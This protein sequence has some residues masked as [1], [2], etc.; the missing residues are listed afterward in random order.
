M[1]DQGNEYNLKRTDLLVKIIGVFITLLTIVIGLVQ[2]LD[3]QSYENAMEFKRVM[4]QKQLSTYTQAC[5]YAG[6]IA[7]N[8]LDKDFNEN[9][10]NFGALYWG[11][12]IMV[13][14]SLVVKAMK[15]FYFATIDYSSTDPQSHMKLKFKAEQLAQACRVSSRKSWNE[16]KSTGE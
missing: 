6:L 11:E 10:K 1:S 12:M 15:E 8:P 5:K 7:T 3:K 14:D 9:I 2:Y 16:L 4:W 13:E